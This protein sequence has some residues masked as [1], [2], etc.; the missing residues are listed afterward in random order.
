MILSVKNLCIAIDG[1]PAVRDLTFSVAA[2]EVL[3]VVGE[4]GCGKSMVNMALMGLLPDGVSASA[5]RMEACGIDLLR[6]RSRDWRA[7]RGGNMAMIF[8]NPMSALNPCLT[9]E[10]QLTESVL[11]THGG[12]SRASARA[13]ALRLLDRVGIAHASARLKSYPHELSGGMAQRIMIAMAVASAPQLLIADEPTTALDVTV[14][15]QILQL[16]EEIRQDTG[17]AMMMVSHDIGVIEQCAHRV[18]VMYSGQI[19]ESGNVGEVIASPRH[20]YTRGLVAAQP[21]RNGQRPKSRLTTIDGSVIP[22]TE[23]VEGC[24]FRS[25]CSRTDHHCVQPPTMQRTEA[26]SHRESRCHW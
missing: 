7:L 4:S 10:R 3:G 20:P 9:I 26:N 22:I 19:V 5:E 16:L 24:R 11:H 14:Q 25:R 6:A 13:E 15:A 18:Q 2:G 23:E 17:M 8:Q 12:M 1:K 21:G